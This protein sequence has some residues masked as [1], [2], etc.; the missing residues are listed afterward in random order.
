M[1]KTRKVPKAKVL[2]VKVT[3][4]N[5]EEGYPQEPRSCPIALAL[6]DLGLDG[7]HVDNDAVE[8]HDPNTGQEVQ[9]DAPK[10]ISKFVDRFDD[11]RTEYD[12]FD[13]EVGDD[14]HKRVKPFAFKIQLPVVVPGK[15]SC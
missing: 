9:L 2:N 13:N 15:I 10:C 3:R 8:F 1:K 5:I 6:Y 12:K 11:T 14:R 4:Q 7:V